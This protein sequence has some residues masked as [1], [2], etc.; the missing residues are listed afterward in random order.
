[1]MNRPVLSLISVVAAGLALSCGGAL[2]SGG[3]TTTTWNG[4]GQGAP[5]SVTV[6]IAS[7]TLDDDCGG[8]AAGDVA[9]GACAD[10]PCGGPPSCRG[11]SLQLSLSSGPGGGASRFS[12]ESVEL[13]DARTGDR[14]ATLTPRGGQ[15]W[16]TTGTYVPWDGAVAPSQSMQVSYPLSGL[17]WSSISGGDSSSAYGSHYRLQVVVE[18][19]GEERTL[20]S[21]DV[22]REPMVVT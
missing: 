13:Y 10:G 3:S 16:S 5:S 1:M 19:D 11:S 20:V 18:I 4:N 12:I 15:T 7:V 8:G 21:S 6:S 14:V 2:V 22:G 17:D 9:A